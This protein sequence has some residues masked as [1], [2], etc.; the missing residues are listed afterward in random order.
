MYNYQFVISNIAKEC[1]KKKAVLQYF[2]RKVK[3][4]KYLCRLDTMLSIKYNRLI[5]K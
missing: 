5:N 1:N 2:A 3:K 4:N